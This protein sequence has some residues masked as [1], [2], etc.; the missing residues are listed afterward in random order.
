MCQIQK[1]EDSSPFDGRLQITQTHNQKGPGFKIPHQQEAGGS[2]ELGV[3]W[4]Y[5]S[6]RKATKSPKTKKTPLRD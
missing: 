1:D 3:I 6:T 2:S 5:R 4:N